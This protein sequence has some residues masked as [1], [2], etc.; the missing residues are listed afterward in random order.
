MVTAKTAEEDIIHG[1]RL[2]AD[3]YV[4]KPF[5]VQELVLRVEAIL[6]RSAKW[7]INQA[8]LEIG[9]LL[10]DTRGLEGR[11]KGT[12]TTESENIQFT[13]REMLILQY[14]GENA[15][16]PVPRSELL[17]EVWGYS[18]SGSFETRTI[19]IH[20]AK[21]RRKIELDPKNPRFLI[22]VRGK[23]YQLLCKS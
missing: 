20:I 13:N 11:V 14:L 17:K 16:R 7:K 2:G 4:S 9:N 5:S 19:D 22:T 21:L 18:K 3:D 15:E 12:E 23:G 10:I 1:L 8:T 6:K